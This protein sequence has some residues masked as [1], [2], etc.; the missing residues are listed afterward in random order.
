MLKAG[1]WG[2]DAA[3]QI[4]NF[5]GIDDFSVSRRAMD[6]RIG[7]H[8]AT[9]TRIIGA[10][11]VSEQEAVDRPELMCGPGEMNWDIEVQKALAFDVGLGACGIMRS[12]NAFQMFWHVQGMKTLY[13]GTIVFNGEELE[14]LPDTCCGYAGKNWGSDYTPI[15]TWLSCNNFTSRTSGEKPPLTSLD[16]GGAVPIVFGKI[17]PRRLLIAFY[18]KGKLFEFNFTKFWLKP[19]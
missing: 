2:K 14:V 17:L 19:K 15:W 12:L 10:V 18:Y 8:T 9:E 1:C 3:V 5:Y 7:P 4:H 6:V 16:V 13:N 11:K